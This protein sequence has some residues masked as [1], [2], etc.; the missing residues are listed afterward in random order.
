MTVL[1]ALVLCGAGCGYRA[2]FAM[3]DNVETIHVKV[4]ENKTF[5][6]DLDFDLTQVVK[7]E[8]LSRTSLT[9]VREK[10]ADVVLS[11]TVR[12]VEKSV[13]KEDI[14]DIPEEVEYKLTVSA[15]AKDRAGR[16]LFRT[17]KL[18]KSARYVVVLGE[19]ERLARS[20]ALREVAEELV[21]QLAESWGWRE[22]K[23]RTETA[24]D[25]GDDEFK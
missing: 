17:A 2:G 24:D 19:D 23:P 18:S 7:R 4:F 13:L 15:D 20:R 3:P 11:C 16:T 5:Y 14:N 12:G 6:R 8:I 25:A 1:G 21:Y 22:D 9:V 10:D